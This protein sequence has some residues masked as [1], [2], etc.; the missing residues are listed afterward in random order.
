MNALAESIFAHAAAEFPKECCG[1]I[2]AKGDK[3]HIVRAKNIDPHPE[4]DFTLDPQAWLEVQDDEEVVGIYHSHPRGNAEPSEADKVSCEKTNL[5]WHIVSWPA[6]GY[7]VHNPCGYKAPYTGRPFVHG[8]LDCY[9]L[10]R[11]WYEG[12]KGIT[13]P[14]YPREHEWWNKGFDLYQNYYAEAGFERR[15]PGEVP[16]PGD[17]LLMQVRSKVP[18]HGAIYLGDGKILHHPCDRLSGIEVYGGLWYKSTTH[19]LGFKHG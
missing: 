6:G 2:V 5:P 11:D 9:S 7:V 16:Q 13:L 3:T 8:L 18:N 19:V 17:V 4:R 14:D 10:I 12:E 15:G 1:L